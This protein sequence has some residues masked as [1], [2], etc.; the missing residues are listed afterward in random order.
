[1]SRR[2]R[3][4]HSTSREPDAHR[5]ATARAPGDGRAGAI[6]EEA[7]TSM[8]D[9][10]FS[11]D[12]FSADPFSGLGLRH[13]ELDDRATLD[14]YFASLARPLSDYT[15][16]QL[17]T[18]RNSLRIL[19][20]E[21]GGHLCVFA[22]GTGDL[23][24]LL[25]PI[26]DTGSDRALRGAFAL[27]DHYNVAHGVPHR[28]RV[29]YAS[30]E[31]IVRFDRAAFAAEP[32]GFDYLYDVNR[33]IDLAGGDLSSKRQAK[34]RF[35]RLHEHYVEPYDA[36]KH[37]ADCRTL[38]NNWKVDQ[39]EGHAAEAGVDTGRVKRLKEATATELCLETAGPLGLKGMVVYAK[40]RPDSAANDPSTPTRHAALSTQHAGFTLRAFTFGEHLGRDQSSITIEK[41][42][43]ATKGLAQFIFSE[44]C[45]TDWADRPLVNVGDDWGLETLA[46]T[47]SSYRPAKRL[48]KYVLRRVPAVVATVPDAPEQPTSNVASESGV[49][50]GQAGVA[51][52]EATAPADRRERPLPRGDLVEAAS[53]GDWRERRWLDARP[54]EAA[55]PLSPMGGQTPLP[56]IVRPASRNDVVAAL[57]LER[58]CFTPSVRLKKRQLQYL[59]RRRSAIFLVAGQG[60]SV[61]GEGVALVRQHKQ[62]R[63]GRIYSLA[64]KAEARGQ[65]VGQKLLVAMIES[66]SDRGVSRV[67]LEVSAANPGAA[68]LYKREGFRVIGKLPDYYGPGHDGIHMIREIKAR[69]GAVTSV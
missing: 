14:P 52:A 34:N 47:K 50:F 49:R 42:D 26:G 54:V 20:K 44:F 58:A 17:F 23:T 8:D 57:E 38:L 22:N 9:D 55:S 31:L 13:V 19:W 10:P 59:Q 28:S 60:D 15:F 29:E 11:A 69:A 36:A 12:P 32:M 18:W 16:S 63:S 65:K 56:V 62:G 37:L 25:P 27:M 40:G 2:S 45:R 4:P 46:W 41:T 48:Q 66:L 5:E 3:H 7:I 53:P 21:I 43:L 61:V 64:V 1:M 24:L 35:L 33:M 6:R 67:Y 30:D 39:D 68:R 51:A